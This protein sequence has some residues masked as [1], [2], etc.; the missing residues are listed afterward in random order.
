MAWSAPRTW[1]V[2]EVPTADLMNQ[3]IRDNLSFLGN[4]HD[5]TGDAGDGGSLGQG[6]VLAIQVFSPR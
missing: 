5:H 1:I 2:G 4:S 3:E 6:H